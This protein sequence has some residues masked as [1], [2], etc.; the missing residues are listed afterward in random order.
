MNLNLCRKVTGK[1]EKKRFLAAVKATEGFLM[2]S[3]ISEGIL[4]LLALKFSNSILSK[5]LIYLRTQ[6]KKIYIG[7]HGVSFFEP[8][9]FFEFG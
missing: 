4:Q 3:C 2:C 8:H 9:D 7:S 6:S 5:G 1:T